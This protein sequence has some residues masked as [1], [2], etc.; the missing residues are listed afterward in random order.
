M[1]DLPKITLIVNSQAT[2]FTARK[3]KVIVSALNSLGNLKTVHTKDRGHA[4]EIAK[5]SAENGVDIVFVLAGDGTLNEAAQSLINTNT[6]L[7]PIPGGSTNVFSRAIGYSNDTIEA[8]GQLIESIENQSYKTIGVGK[9]DDRIFLFNAGFG[10]DAEVIAR[11][12]RNTK[13]KTIAAHPYTFYNAL[14]TYSHGY[15]KKN[16]TLRMTL[17]G[18]VNPNIRILSSDPTVFTNANIVVVSN[19]SPWTYFGKRE[20]VLAPTASIDNELTITA[21]RSLSLIKLLRFGASAMGRH[22]TVMH[23]KDIAHCEGVAHS[24][25]QANTNAIP[26]QLDGDYIG[27]TMKVEVDFLPNALKIAIP[28]NSE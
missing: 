6:V 16:Q 18:E 26:Y 10:L 7:A 2:N 27:S 3:L 8:L 14:A 23:H 12:E 24:V 25:I 21:I 5:E 28:L 20:I 19:L 17:D 11:V 4:S 13:I 9:V 1:T 15:D 22:R